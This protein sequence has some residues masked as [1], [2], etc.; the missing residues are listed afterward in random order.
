MDQLT[1]VHIDLAKLWTAAMERVLV[2]LQKSLSQGL[3]KSTGNGE[4]W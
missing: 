2:A 1:M 4:D 3:T